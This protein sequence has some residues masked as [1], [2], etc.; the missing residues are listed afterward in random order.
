M[1]M[2][3]NVRV[4]SRKVGDGPWVNVDER[5]PRSRR[6]GPKPQQAGPEATAEAPK[7]LR[8]RVAL[9]IARHFALGL[10]PDPETGEKTYVPLATA[11]EVIALIAAE[12]ESG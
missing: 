1:A 12:G 5:S 9:V 7:P 4:V 10:V 2:A 6:S 3:D 8:D 11:D